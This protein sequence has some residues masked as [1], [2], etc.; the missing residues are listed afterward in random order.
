MYQ[1]ERRK[2]PDVSEQIA[3]M[4]KNIELLA[5]EFKN[6]N[7]NHCA[8]FEVINCEVKSIKE[9][10]YGNGKKGLVE[11]AGIIENT[12]QVLQWVVGFGFILT[13]VIISILQLIKK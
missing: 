9:S 6:S 1:K 10:I 11:R 2:D 7:E 4:A 3:L 5:L 12:I 13:G 8:K